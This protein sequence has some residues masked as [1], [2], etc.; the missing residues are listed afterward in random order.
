MARLLQVLVS[1]AAF[2]ASAPAIAQETGAKASAPASPE[3]A[4]AKSWSF[5]ASVNVYFVP[6]DRNYAQ[7]TV[8]ADHDRLHLEA[9]YNYEAIEAGSAW[10]G[11]NF[12]GEGDLTWQI[13]PMIGGV[14]GRATGIAAGFKVS[15]SWWKLTLYSEGEFV[16]D[17]GATDGHFFYSWSELSLAPVDWFRF[18]LVAQRTRTYETDLDIQRGFLAGFIYGGASIT[19]YMFNPDEEKPVYVLSVALSF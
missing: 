16:Y 6:E 19:G 12:G 8:T 7:P 13:T 17:T 1:A 4:D 3:E 10:V 5:S 2:F 14:F 11:C 18:G 15:L 9:R